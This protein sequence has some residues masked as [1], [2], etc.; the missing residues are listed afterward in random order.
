MKHLQLYLSVLSFEIIVQ[1]GLKLWMKKLNTLQTAA[2]I[3]QKYIYMDW[4]LCVMYKNNPHSHHSGIIK[5]PETRVRSTT[6]KC[7]TK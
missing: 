6:Q 5:G 4:L 2:G 1:I 3:I 7:L